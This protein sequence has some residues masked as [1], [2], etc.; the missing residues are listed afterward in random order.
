M[1]GVQRIFAAGPPAGI[2]IYALAAEK[3]LAWPLP[4]DSRQRACLAAVARDLPFIG[5]PAIRGAETLFDPLSQWR[6]DLIIDVG[7]VD[8]AYISAARHSSEST[9]IPYVLVQ[10]L[11]ATYPQQLREVGRLIGA[12]QR[13]EMLAEHAEGILTR[14]AA[15]SQG[16]SPQQRPSVYYARGVDGLETAPAGSAHAEVIELAGGRNVAVGSNSKTIL[17]VSIEQIL[18]WDPHC[19]IV[20]QRECLSHINIHPLW[21][22][23]QAVRSGNVYCI[24]DAPFSW[25]DIPP[26]INRL[27]GVNWLLALLYPRRF[28]ADTDLP[29][30]T[31]RFYRSFYGV[32]LDL[33]AYRQLVK[34]SP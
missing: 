5:R 28:A 15:L 3:L 34:A 14:A 2:L 25:F 21:Q 30:E 11:M 24:P 31:M 20:Q 32:S 23:L 12:M 13:G 18:E 8:Q 26:G 17:R 16:I 27:L 6:S 4:L 29:R 9:G 1:D 10:G 33:N 7:V 22:K 19:L